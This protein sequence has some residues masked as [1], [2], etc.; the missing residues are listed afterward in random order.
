MNRLLIK[1][2]AILALLLSISEVASGGTVNI[3][4][5]LNGI[6]TSAMLGEVSHVIDPGSG[7][8][9]I[10]VVPA[11][12]YV[13]KSVTAVKVTDGGNAQSRL[14]VPAV[15]IPIEVSQ[16]SEENTWTFIM[17][18][19]EYDVEV[20]VNFIIPVT[21]YFPIWVMGTQVNNVNKDN[22]LGDGK[23]RFNPA[24]STLSLYWASVGNVEDT[25]TI[26]STSL[27]SLRVELHGNNVI[28]FGVAGFKS[29]NKASTASLTFVTSNTD[30]GQLSWETNGGVLAEGFDVTYESPLKL[31]PSGNL[32]SKTNIVDYGLMIGT[33]VVNSVNYM[34]VLKNGTV[35][36]SL[37][38][39]VLVLRNAKLINQP[40]TCNLDGGLTIY[41]LGKSTI[42]GKE[43][44]ITTSKDHSLIV[45][46]T[47]VNAPGSLT[48]TKTADEGTWISGFA[49]ASV[50]NDYATTVVGDTMTIARTIPISPIISETDD[51]EQP[52]ADK[53][54]SVFGQAASGEDSESYV[55]ITIENVLYTIKAG[56]YNEGTEGDQNDPP[57]INLTEIPADM[58]EV[59]SKIPGTDSYANA[60]KGLTIEVPKGNGQVMVRGEIG[61]NAK[62][63]VK[64]GSNP[65]FIFP[66]EEYP[67]FNKLQTIYIPYS[68]PE[69]TFVYIYLAEIITPESSRLEGPARGRVLTGHIKVS[70]VGASAST[71]V[72]NQSYCSSTNSISDRVIVYDL[73]NGAKTADNHGIVMTTVGVESYYA[74]ARS[75][76]GAPRRVIEQKRITE[77]GASVFDNLEDKDQILY[78][79]ISG[80]DVKDVTINR[81]AGMFKGF[82]H[83]TLFYL[84]AN[85]DDGGEDNVI[86]DGNCE[87]LNLVDDMDFRAPKDFTASN[88]TLERTFETGVTSTVFLPFALTKDQA[89]SFGA[90]HTFKEIHGANAVFNYAETNGTKANTP[91]IFLPS[92]DTKIEA[93]NVSVEGQNAFQAA[94][95]NL[96]G[97]YEKLQWIDEQTDIYCFE[98][99]SS[100]DGAAGDFV[101]VAAGACLPPFQAFLRANS[102]APSRLTVVVGDDTTTGITTHDSQLAPLSPDSWY[103]VSGQR[104]T[105]MPSVKGLFINNGKKVIVR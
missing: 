1:T 29:R 84:P 97:T 91:Y 58:K 35:M 17:P 77:L 43:N 60:F 72:S 98:A 27:P 79:D 28:K 50:P 39:N 102:S 45:F 65:P 56:D 73:P 16:G 34:D 31:Q 33:T 53:P 100:G 63:A 59:L 47:S 70:T 37:K 57:G 75:G 41:L 44:L 103:T 18:S 105:G 69:P 94:S 96:V 32:I 7:I 67:D 30:P 52:Q 4:T 24:T 40:I 19:E 82:G 86:L 20:I 12:D 14:K 64:V 25:D 10:T 22:V 49:A 61:V 2:F 8:C 95:G 55:N 42:S 6:A 101:R 48:L 11:E 87:R 80:T 76:M 36:Y 71:V 46:T 26:F 89:D 104:L 78:V 54:T 90:F 93:S 3:V 62:L 88:A 13:V 23:V 83:N 21:E 15:S 85:N 74:A 51:G 38:D 5:K 66:N 99:P 9:T 92:S 68:C 81:S